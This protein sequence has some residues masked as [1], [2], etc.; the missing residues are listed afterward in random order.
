MAPQPPLGLRTLALQPIGI[1]LA[2]E[3]SSGASVRST[4]AGLWPQVWRQCRRREVVIAAKSRLGAAA[5]VPARREAFQDSCAVVRRCH[6]TV[7]D[8]VQVAR[9]N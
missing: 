8:R 9:P 1:R 7:N 2:C 4:T 3:L 6:H 5:R